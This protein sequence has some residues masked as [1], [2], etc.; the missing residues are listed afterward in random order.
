MSLNS[1]ES[2]RLLQRCAASISEV[3]QGVQHFQKLPSV[4]K[5]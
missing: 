4:F 2:L 5:T 3:N 1:S